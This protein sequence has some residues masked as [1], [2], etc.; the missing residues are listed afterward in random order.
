MLRL[1]EKLKY[2]FLG[3]LLTFAGFMFANM[4]SDIQAQSG[5]E[6]IDE[7]TVRKVTVLEDLTVKADDG[8]DRVVISSDEDGGNITCLGPERRRAASLLVNEMGGMV[9]VHG[10]EGGGASL[11]IDEEGGSVAIFPVIEGQGGAALGIFDGNGV[12][13][14]VDRFGEFQS[15][16]Q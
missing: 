9:A 5:S 6:T 3:G 14:T 4:N 16:E 13:I 1:R 2:M 7:L 15:F 8:E 11:S 10:K 12:I